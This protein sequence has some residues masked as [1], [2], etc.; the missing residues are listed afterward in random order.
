MQESYEKSAKDMPKSTERCTNWA[1][2][3]SVHK[4]FAAFVIITLMFHLLLLF[5]VLSCADM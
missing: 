1:V 3:V 5:V 2:H 4:L